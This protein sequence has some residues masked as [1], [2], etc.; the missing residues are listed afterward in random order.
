MRTVSVIALQT[1]INEAHPPSSVS[2][3]MMIKSVTS[4]MW[5]E[6]QKEK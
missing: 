1:R 4:G 2:S 5:W 6:L 3:S